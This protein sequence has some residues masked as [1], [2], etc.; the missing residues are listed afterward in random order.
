MHLLRGGLDGA[1]DRPQ[2]HRTNPHPGVGNGPVVAAGQSGRADYLDNPGCEGLPVTDIQN[3]GY[4]RN[5]GAT[6]ESSITKQPASQPSFTMMHSPSSQARSW[7]HFSH[8]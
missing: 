2:D 5:G 4:R 8:Y 1:L 3:A 6:R 7:T